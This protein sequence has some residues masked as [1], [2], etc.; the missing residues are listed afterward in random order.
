MSDEFDEQAERE[1]AEKLLDAIGKMMMVDDKQSAISCLA[2]A[3]RDAY[4][5]GVD[6]MT[7][8]AIEVDN[9]DIADLRADLETLREMFSNATNSRN[10]LFEY[11]QDGEEKFHLPM[12]SPD[13]RVRDII[14]SLRA[15]VELL[16]LDLQAFL[17][18]IPLNMATAPLPTGDYDNDMGA[19]MAWAEQNKPQAPTGFEFAEWRIDLPDTVLCVFERGDTKQIADLRAERDGLRHSADAINKVNDDLRTLC[20]ALTLGVEQLTVERDQLKAQLD[21][22]KTLLSVAGIHCD[23]CMPDS[24]LT[25]SIRAAMEKKP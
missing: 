21:E 24:P 19:M 22:W 14:H 4:H 20:E 3:L 17:V 12:S 18:S 9:R 13:W 11:A 16:K 8:R 1:N 5:K 23:V 7:R 10:N 2:A 6:D 25:N 15:E